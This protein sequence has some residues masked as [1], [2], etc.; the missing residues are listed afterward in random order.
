MKMQNGKHG[1]GQSSTP[2]DGGGGCS[3]RL[4]RNWT[5]NE[6]SSIEKTKNDNLKIGQVQIK[7]DSLKEKEK[8]QTGKMNK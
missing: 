3:T 1:G 6:S 8:C 5:W 4:W 2:S 7:T